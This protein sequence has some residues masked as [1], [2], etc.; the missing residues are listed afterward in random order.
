MSK[1][2]VTGMIVAVTWAIVA[3][4]LVILAVRAGYPTHAA[5]TY[6]PG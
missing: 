6:C 2:Q 4:V 3:T 5:T 1:V